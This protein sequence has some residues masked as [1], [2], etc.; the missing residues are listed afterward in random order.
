[1]NSNSV[2]NYNQNEINQTGKVSLSNASKEQL[3]TLNGIG[4]KIADRIVKYRRNKGGFKTIDEIKQVKGIGDA[5][6]EKIKTDIT[7]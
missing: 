2:N 4:E 5:L 3:Q 7:P 6:F 1:M